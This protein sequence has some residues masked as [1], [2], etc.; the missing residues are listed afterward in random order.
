MNKLILLSF[1]LFFR[2]DNQLNKTTV[3]EQQNNSTKEKLNKEYKYDALSNI[4]KNY[5]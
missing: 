5:K 3:H 1:I 2:C 4:Y